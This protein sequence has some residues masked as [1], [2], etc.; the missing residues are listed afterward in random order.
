MTLALAGVGNA[1]T[2]DAL[3]ASALGVPVVA[4]ASR[5]PHRTRQWAER[6]GVPVVELESLPAGADALMVATP[7]DAHE[8][9]VQASL[10]SATPVMIETPLATTL[11]AADRMVAA[12]PHRRVLYGESLAFSPLTGLALSLRSVLGRWQ[13]LE[14]RMLSPR[15]PWAAS[16]TTRP[17]GGALFDVGAHGLALML[18]MTA[19]DTPTSVRA[20]M[21]FDPELDVD[22]ETESIIS[23]ASGATAR[24]EASWRH[25]SAIWDLQISG[26]RGVVRVEFTPEPSVEVNGEPQELPPAPTSVDPRLDRLGHLGRLRALTAMTAGT[27]SPLD[28]DFGRQVLEL[29]CAIS[30]AAHRGGERPLPF[31]GRRDVTAAELSNP[32]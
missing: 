29:I 1:A 8:G 28:V 17:A 11:A 4:V 12:D 23:F 25:Q 13:H 16:A 10:R 20:A 2:L 5:D 21:T 14:V 26:D 19:D 22:T 27:P 15:P 6:A 18:S 3:C 9:L 31:D 32:G 24:L 30:D 7:P